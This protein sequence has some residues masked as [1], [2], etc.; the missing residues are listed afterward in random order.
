MVPVKTIEKLHSGKDVAIIGFGD[1]LTQ[2]WMARKGYLDFFGEMLGN[3]FPTSRVKIIN[4]GVPGDS[5]AGGLHR[6]AWDVIDQDPDL[7][8]VQFA[9]NDAFMGVPL[10]IFHEQ[11]SSIVQSIKNDTEAEPVLLTSVYIADKDEYRYAQKYYDALQRVSSAEKIPL[12]A[13]HQYWEQA[14]KNGVDHASLVQWDGVH[15]TVEGYRLMAEAV[16]SMFDS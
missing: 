15:P 13:V 12:V 11:I 16:F 14:V 2:G 7:V 4:R 3:K 5:A 1:S 6:L 9:L 8:F 10:N